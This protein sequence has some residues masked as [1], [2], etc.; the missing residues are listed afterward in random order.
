MPRQIFLGDS[1]TTP[2]LKTMGPDTR[3]YKALYLTALLY[4]RN[5]ITIR[6][7]LKLNNCSISYAVDES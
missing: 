5:I 2:G 3:T 6:S 4:N 1:D 7:I